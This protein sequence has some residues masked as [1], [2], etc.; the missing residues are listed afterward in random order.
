MSDAEESI[1]DDVTVS[2]RAPTGWSA[3][4]VTREEIEE[5]TEY[6]EETDDEKEE[7]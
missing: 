2:T 5:A 3:V 4:I 7:E 1:L 6:E